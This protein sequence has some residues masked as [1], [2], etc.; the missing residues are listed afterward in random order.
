MGPL[1]GI[2]VL[3][4]T[5]AVAG[6]VCT[7]FLG[8][9]GA[10]II[11]IEKPGR[12]DNTRYN[13]I[14]DRFV[15]AAVTAG[16]DYFLA[17]NRNKRSVAVDMKTERGKEIIL[18]LAK[19]ADVVVQN[20]RPGSVQ[21]L[22]LDYQALSK[23]NP[24]IIYASLTGWGN[25]GP[26]ADKPGMDLAV[27]ARAGVLAM[28]GHPGGP[29]TRPGASVADMS[30]GVYLALAIQGALIHRMKTGEGQ[31]V[32]ASLFDGMLAMLANFS[33]AVMEGGA[34]LEPVGTGHPQIVPYQAFPT[35]D[36]YVVVACATNRLFKRL[37]EVLE[38]PD[39]LTDPRF[40]T[41]IERVDNREAIVTI[42]SE[43][44]KKRT[45]A[46]WL[47]ALD[48][49]GVVC[50]PVNTVAQGF[51]EPQ[52]VVNDMIKRV[53]HPVYGTLRL[54]RAPM[55]LSKSD[56]EV[57]RPPP[58]LGQHTSEVLRSAG[59]SDAEVASMMADSVIA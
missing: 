13:N 51:A 35:S 44:F 31:E 4:L 5:H 39:L 49:G 37:T 42:L 2:R 19:D 1:S 59:Y 15:K 58:L 3:D 27:Q 7:M 25:E 47:L 53:Q 52:L 22:G 17:I 10:E 34:H 23:V 45:T 55:K 21:R 57:T 6:P 8:D 12:G 50:A 20:F 32:S 28:T 11:K 54:M 48:A 18:R 56:C 36:S 9:L 38:R 26:L 46:E 41:N 14:S 40:K 43:I 24:S 16:G 30:G 33:V 29:P